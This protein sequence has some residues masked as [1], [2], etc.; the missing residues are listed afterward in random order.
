MHAISTLRYNAASGKETP[1]YRL[2]KSYRDLGAEW[3]SKQA[4]DRLD[5]EGILRGKGWKEESINTAL[6][7]L[8]VRTIYAPS[9]WATHRIMR[10]NSAACELYSD[11]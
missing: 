2:K 3:L 7:H 10:D 6:S 4:I 11:T 8:I 1:Y 5:I 9:E